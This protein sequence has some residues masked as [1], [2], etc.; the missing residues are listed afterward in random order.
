MVPFIEL[1]TRIGAGLE[2]NQDFCM[3]MLGLRCLL[4]LQWI[5]QVGS[6]I[7]RLKS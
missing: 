6:W 7:N 1:G 2:E 4:D 3:N 5:S